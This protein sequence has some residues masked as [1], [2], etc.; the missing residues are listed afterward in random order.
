MLKLFERLVTEV[1]AIDEKEH[2]ARACELDE[3]VDEVDGREGL[4][5]ASGHLDQGARAILNQ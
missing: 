5:A 4:T 1:A 2:A 3:P